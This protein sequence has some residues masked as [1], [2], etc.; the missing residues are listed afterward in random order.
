MKKMS[1]PE[2]D[3]L[4]ISSEPAF[5]G[6]MLKVFVDIAK[7]PNGRTSTREVVRHPGAAAV[8]AVL[9]DGRILLEKQ[10]RYALD[11][12]MYE[13]PAGK[14]DPGE[15]PEHCARRELAEETGYEAE[16]WEYLT[17]I[18]TTPGFTDEVIHL[19]K[20]T[21]L[22][23]H[24]QHLDEDEAL[25]LEAFTVDEIRAA[26][27]DG[28]LYDAKSLAALGVASLLGKL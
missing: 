4:R 7:L 23:Q 28:L 15:E 16:Q 8:L 14:L 11:T 17:S 19:Y 21:G 18:A 24:G 3:E 12:V 9:P 5:Q 13:V 10:Y 1:D 27:R 2:L 6:R 25:K 22:H 26:V 20:A